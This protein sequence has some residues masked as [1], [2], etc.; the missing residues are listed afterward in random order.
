[1]KMK[2]ELIDHSKNAETTI[3]QGAGICYGKP[4]KDVSRIKRLKQHGHL[5]TFRF[6]H[7]VFRVEDISRAC[8]NQIVRHKHLDFL[9]ES[10]RYVDQTDR[11][12]VTPVMDTASEVLYHNEMSNAFH[13][14][15]KLIANGVPKED[16]RGILPGNT[17]TSMY[18]AGNFQAWSD[19]LNLRVDLHA[20]QEVRIVFLKIWIMLHLNFPLAFPDT[21]VR[22][23]FTL[24][25]WCEKEGFTG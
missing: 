25:E 2:V 9:V 10:Q 13:T 3:A 11:G 19:A 17:L 7:A 18:I 12:Y 15:G 24:L 8:Q 23:G 21:E 16:A 20:Q 5:A 6:A 4:D 1:M 14:Y 22:N